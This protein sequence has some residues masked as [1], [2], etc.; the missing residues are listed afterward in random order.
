MGAET[1]GPPFEAHRRPTPSGPKGS[2]TK[3]LSYI[4]GQLRMMRAMAVLLLAVTA[5][6][7]AATDLVEFARCLNRAGATFYTASGGVR[8]A[9]A[10]RGCSAARSAT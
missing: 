10:R 9:R 2:S 1:G 5:E 8:I 3:L 4:F 6:R 7:A